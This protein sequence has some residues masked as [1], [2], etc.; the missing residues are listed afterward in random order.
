[1]L[2]RSVGFGFV[3]FG[4]LAIATACGGTVKQDTGSP[5]EQLRTGGADRCKAACATIVACGL[6]SRSCD[7]ACSC[8]ADGTDCTC[9]P[10]MCGSPTT[11]SCESDC[12]KS[13]QKV[14]DEE[15]TCDAPMLALLDCLA[16]ASCTTAAVPCK[17][18]E[19]AFK[20]CGIAH[21]PKDSVTPPT[22]NGTPGSSSS[23]G[24]PGS[25]TCA[26]SFGFGSAAADGSLPSPPGQLSCGSGFEQCSDGRIYKVECRTTAGV[27]LD[28]SCL[29]DG[30]AGATF[31]A[32]DCSQ[33]QSVLSGYCGWDL[34]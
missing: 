14:V 23:P 30:V 29:V 21:R 17:A 15:P 32:G 19:D 25:V 16:V 6:D 3:V 20:S 26:I 31:S 5:S 27:G 9:P 22:A 13:V 33:T 2:R 8:P 7:C 28:C 12:A 10:C 18:E 4:A 11:S 34:G 24:S 1:M